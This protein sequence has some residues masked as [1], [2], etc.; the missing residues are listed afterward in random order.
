MHDP[1]ISAGD[2]L[3]IVIKLAE[4]NVRT[5]KQK[6]QFGNANTILKKRHK[7][8]NFGGRKNISTQASFRGA[9]II[10]SSGSGKSRHC[11]IPSIR[12]MD[13]SLVIHDPSGELYEATRKDVVAKGF[14]VKRFNPSDQRI[15][16]SFNYL[17][18]VSSF[19]EASRKA[20]SLVEA[21]YGNQLSF[22]ET[23]AIDIIA[24]IIHLLA[25]APNLS[26]TLP[27]LQML[28]KELVYNQSKV[29]SYVKSLKDDKLLK[30]FLAFGGQEEKM[31]SGILA[32]A[33]SCLSFLSDETVLNITSS[34]SIDL[35]SLRTQKTVLYIQSKTTDTRYHSIL[36]SL[37]FETIFEEILDH[38]PQANELDVFCLIDEAGGLFIP[39]L[40]LAMANV[41]KYRCG[42]LLCVQDVNQLISRY[43]KEEAH[44]IRSNAYSTF[45]FSGVELGEAQY[46][47]KLCGSY[48]YVD[49]RGVPRL[50]PLITANEI[51]MLPSK[52]ALLIQG[53]SS[54]MKVKLKKPKTSFISRFV[55]PHAG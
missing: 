48:E 4:G 18:G 25:K 5:H 17:K 54:P 51:R 29:L 22:W 20:R 10:G 30:Q 26:C 55:H 8:F 36:N 1:F 46:L 23:S 16:E 38:L 49:E 47:E 53:N 40:P 52:T 11:I 13:G 6:A 12:T 21:S 42:V 14:E 33:L 7:G 44:T 45:V 31:K 2:A 39:T 35:E 27:N 41:R 43:G 28:L 34:D 24:S 32:T 15:S 9:L 19:G 3:E 50:R 37:L